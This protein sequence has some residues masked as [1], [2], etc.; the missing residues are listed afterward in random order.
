MKQKLLLLAMALLGLSG[1]AMADGISFSGEIQA[2]KYGLVTIYSTVESKHYNGF[3]IHITEASI[4]EGITIES[5]VPT[6]ELKETYPDIDIQHSL[7]TDGGYYVVMGMTMESATEYLPIGE[8]IPIVK[9]YLKADKSFKAGAKVELE[10]DHGEFSQVGESQSVHFIGTEFGKENVTIPLQVVTAYNVER[11]IDEN[12]KYEIEDT[13]GNWVENVNVIRSIKAD[14]W[15]TICLPFSMTRA[16]KQAAFGSDAQ[17]A[18]LSG[19]FDYDV[20][21]KLLDLSVSPL[22]T[23]AGLQANTFYFVKTPQDVEQ[24]RV[25]NVLVKKEEVKTT[26]LWYDEEKDADITLKSVGVYAPQVI[27]ENGVFL[28]ENKF[29]YSTGNSNIKPMRGY[30]VLDDYFLNNGGG[31]ANIFLSLDGETTGIK[32]NILV[33]N[34]AVYSISGVYMGK[35]SDMKKLP[36]GMYIV[37]NK[38]VTVK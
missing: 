25:E 26:S 24:F 33:D 8:N 34:D 22:R 14:N 11:T 13:Y 29:Y 19:E 38:K 32:T 16:Q 5:V 17:F 36:R 2:E 23:S 1:T 15:S 31:E 6:N 18:T 28:S 7:N 3:E 10:V 30:L 4:P 9:V 12:S 21:K 27:P 35:A 20:D 37:N